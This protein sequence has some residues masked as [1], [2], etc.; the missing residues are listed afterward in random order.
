[1]KTDNWI[2]VDE[3]MPS[4]G[5]LVITFHESGAVTLTSTYVHMNELQFSHVGAYGKVLY[6]Q[7]K[8]KPPK[9]WFKKVFG[10]NL[11]RL[12]KRARLTQDELGE[13]FGY[14]HTS[15]NNWEHGLCFPNKKV[16]RSLAKMFECSVE[17]LTGGYLHD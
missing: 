15:V 13:A 14:S 10:E 4:A 5:S 8:P 16:L 6:W 9:E 2:S 7:P 11:T 3:Y 12:R 17:E 1:M